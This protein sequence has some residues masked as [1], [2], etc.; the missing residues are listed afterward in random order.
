[1]KFS[2]IID[3]LK[4]GHAYR[5]QAENWR[6]KFISCHVDQTVPE[7]VVPKMNS[8]PQGVKRLMEARS[9]YFHDQVLL[10]EK[11]EDKSW[12]YKATG[13]TPS[14]DDIFADDWVIFP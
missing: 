14:W 13:Y 2:E 10:F 7:D 4:S 6:N 3:G 1:M 8:L 9:I 11:G 12:N 5:R